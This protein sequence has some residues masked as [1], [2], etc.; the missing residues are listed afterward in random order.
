M[1]TG[2]RNFNTPSYNPPRE[3]FADTGSLVGEARVWEILAK[4]ASD[5]ETAEQLEVRMAR[6]DPVIT[7]AS[8]ADNGGNL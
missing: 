6:E 8:P 4:T 3:H 5:F 7:A 1:T 2:R